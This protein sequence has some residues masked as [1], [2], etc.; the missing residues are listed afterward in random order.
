M[1]RER[2]RIG[3]EN[4]SVRLI[5]QQK[6][7]KINHHPGMMAQHPVAR[8]NAKNPYYPLR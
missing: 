8:E 5:P 7:N 3:R 2:C 1:G 6:V 4:E